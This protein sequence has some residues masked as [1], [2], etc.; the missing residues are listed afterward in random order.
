MVL[1]FVSMSKPLVLG[2]ESSCDETAVGLVNGQGAILAND[3][4]SQYEHH[5]NWGGV[6]PELAARA[7]LSRIE[8]LVEGAFE[9]SGVQW[10]DIDAIAVTGGPGLIG[11]VIVGVMV[12]KAMAAFQNKPFYAVNH[13]EG[14]ALSP[15]LS[16]AID[17]PFILLL[18]SGG[19]T[20]FLLV[21]GVGDYTLLGTTMDDAVGEAFDKTA[22]LLGLPYP[23]GPLIEK[24]AQNGNPLAFRLPQPLSKQKN[25][26][27]SFSGLKTAVRQLIEKES[28]SKDSSCFA[29]LCASFQY[30]VG[31]VLKNKLIYAFQEAE[32]KLGSVV[33]RFVVAG[34]VSANRYLRHILQ[35]VC[36]EN[37]V[38]FYAPEQALC[39]DNGAMI[40]WAGVE[41]IK[42]GFPPSSL[43]FA[44]R[45]RW[46]LTDLKEKKQ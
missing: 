19:H 4:Y 44:P 23:G 28:I 18:V 32:S 24:S 25:C 6:V 45:P 34:G 5:V 22:R 21:K 20:Q 42:A 10:Q 16:A 36:Q 41:R 2:I 40:A 13:L 46:P 31:E 30:T 9:S 26:M 39:T 37:S 33:N 8:K 29:D 7:H 3:L 27:L 12:A 11:G 15:R 17:F 38:K 43:T 1:F 14:H 35:E